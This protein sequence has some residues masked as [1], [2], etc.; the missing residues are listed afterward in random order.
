MAL[1]VPAVPGVSAFVC[2]TLRKRGLMPKRMTSERGV[3]EIGKEQHGQT[4]EQAGIWWL[5]A[6]RGRLHHDAPLALAPPDAF[7]LS[8]LLLDVPPQ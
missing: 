8:G 6:L 1:A 3:G 5:R 4:H 7:I 2:L